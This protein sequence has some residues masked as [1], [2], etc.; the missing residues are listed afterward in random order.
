MGS[1]MRPAILDTLRVDIQAGDYSLRA[2]GS[3]VKFPGY[4]AAFALT[5]EEE[6]K[7]R[8]GQA[9][10]PALTP[11]EALKL[12]ELIPEQHFT[13]PPPRYSEATLVK[14]LES[15][16]IGRPSTYAPIIQTIQDRGYVY[17]DKRR[18]RPTPLGR[19]VTDQLVNHFPQI[20]DIDFT[21]HVEDKLDA[22]EEGGNNWVQLV[23]EF[24]EPFERLLAEAE[25]NMQRIRPVAEPTDQKCE[26]C[27]KPMVV[28]FSRR[29]PFLGCSGYPECKQTRPLEGEQEGEER[30]P[31]QAPEETDQVCE[32]CGQ[33]M[34]IRSSRRGRFLGCKG[35]PKCRNTKPLEGEEGAAPAPAEVRTEIC[36]ECGKPM[37]ARSSRRGPFLGCSGYPKCRHTQPLPKAE[38]EAES[39]AA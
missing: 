6:E 14:E 18:F 39:E 30:R 28:R 31:R 1:Q 4:R 13:E 12:V 27:G 3:R 23:R 17:L 37:V 26:E 5:E 29:G 19:V 25:G 32:K 16:G 15:R 9:E 11:G 7:E 24:H 35:F 34:V 22:V 36:P 33:P 2:T 20:M 10:L 8:E 38:S 21:A